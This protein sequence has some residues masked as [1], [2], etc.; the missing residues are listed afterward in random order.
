M[1]SRQNKNMAVK[2]RQQSKKGEERH[3]ADTICVYVFVEMEAIWAQ[4]QLLNICMGRLYKAFMILPNYP[5]FSS[6]KMIQNDALLMKSIM[7]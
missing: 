6:F 4:H 2:F 5:L 1:C 7:K 3:F